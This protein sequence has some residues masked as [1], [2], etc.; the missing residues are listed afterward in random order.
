MLVEWAPWAH[1]HDLP[2][3]WRDANVLLF[4]VVLADF[5]LIS[6]LGH[7]DDDIDYTGTSGWWSPEIRAAREK[8]Q[9]QPGE[10]VGYAVTGKADTWSIGMVFV[11]FR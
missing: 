10:P 9:Q 6:D 1:T 11:G 8:Q 2:Q 5:G 3:D 7:S 4:N